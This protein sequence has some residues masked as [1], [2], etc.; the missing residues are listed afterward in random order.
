M[1]DVVFSLQR[2]EVHEYYYYEN[3]DYTN[4]VKDDCILMFFPN[5]LPISGRLFEVKCKLPKTQI[6]VEDEVCL[7][8]LYILFEVVC[9]I[10]ESRLVSVCGYVKV[11]ENQIVRDSLVG[12]IVDV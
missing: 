1:F 6:I 12:L 11:I 7:V 5:S 9:E 4:N 8:E 3:C 10:H 2:C